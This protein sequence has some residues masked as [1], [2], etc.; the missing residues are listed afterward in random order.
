MRFFNRLQKKP[1]NDAKFNNK[2]SLKVSEHFTNHSANDTNINPQIIFLP[3]DVLM[4]ILFYL[5]P[6]ELCHVGETCKLL[7]GLASNE[8]LWGEFI[9]AEYLNGHTEVGTSMQNKKM[10]LDFYDTILDQYQTFAPILPRL[11][12]IFNKINHKENVETNIQLDIHDFHPNTHEN[13]KVRNSRKKVSKVQTRKISLANLLT[14]VETLNTVL[15]FL[16]KMQA[17]D[18]NVLGICGWR[19]LYLSLVSM[20]KMHGATAVLFQEVEP[21]QK[22]LELLRTE[23]L[24]E[25][26]LSRFAGA[27][28]YKNLI[29]K[30]NLAAII[31]EIG[32]KLEE[33]RDRFAE[34][35][36][37]EDIARSVVEGRD[38]RALSC[39]GSRK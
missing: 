31:T 25:G 22:I 36:I 10:F 5:N 24:K 26:N 15:D 16:S 27:L 21:L 37:G 8:L 2:H 19:C 11:K 29:F 28:E 35:V 17:T 33:S 13:G 18:H 6:Q 12:A 30:D 32:M 1:K 7:Y 23:T 34:D 39:F 38:R 14:V 3:K 20:A 9:K 4:L